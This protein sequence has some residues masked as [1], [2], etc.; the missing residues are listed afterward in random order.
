MIRKTLMFVALL[1]NVGLYSTATVRGDGFTSPTDGGSVCVNTGGGSFD[2]EVVVTNN[3]PLGSLNPVG[4][5]VELLDSDEDVVN[6]IIDMDWTEVQNVND[7]WVFTWGDGMDKPTTAGTYQLMFS[8]NYS[9]T[10]L[11]PYSKTISVSFGICI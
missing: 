8:C 10:R 7:I 1:I 3:Q 11:V 5:S 2:V 6:S 9:Q 4:A